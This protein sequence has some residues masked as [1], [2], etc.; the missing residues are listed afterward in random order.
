MGYRHKAAGKFYAKCVQAKVG[1]QPI[2]IRLDG[3]CKVEVGS[4]VRWKEDIGER[5]WHTGIVENV[6]PLRIMRF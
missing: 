4:K 3:R 5:V 1:T 2:S 6:S